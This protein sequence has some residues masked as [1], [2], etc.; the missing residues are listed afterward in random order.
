MLLC[1]IYAFAY[2]GSLPQTSYGVPV[3]QTEPVN[4]DRCKF[5][6]I[7]DDGSRLYVLSNRPK[8]CILVFDLDGN[9]QCT[10]YIYIESKGS[11]K[12]AAD[13]GQL[14][15]ADAKR[16]VYIFKNNELVTFLPAREAVHMM[17]QY[18]FGKTQEKYYLNF[19]SIWRSDDQGEVC[20]VRRA[21]HAVLAQYHLV[22]LA[23]IVLSIGASRS[24]FYNS[25]RK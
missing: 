6:Q 22:L 14:Y 12:I 19:G 3:V 18:D 5:L 9:Y 21:V 16:N 13:N 4:I 25:R 11:L 10:Y 17:D 20:V 8:E 1:L 2:P 15:V 7:V 24:Y 23:L